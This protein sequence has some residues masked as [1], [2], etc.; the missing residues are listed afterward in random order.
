MK[1]FAF[2]LS[3]S[4]IL[5]GCTSETEQKKKMQKNETILQQKKEEKPKIKELE[6]EEEIVNTIVIHDNPNDAK[7]NLHVPDIDFENLTKW[8]KKNT[9]IY[10]E[11]S[12]TFY[13]KPKFSKDG[14]RMRKVDVFHG[15]SL[16]QTLKYNGVFYAIELLDWNFDGYK[17]F[18]ILESAGATGNYFYQIYLF[19]PISKKFEQKKGFENWGGFLDVKN[20]QLVSHFRSGMDHDS[21]EYYKIKNG[22]PVF[23]HGKVS[24]TYNSDGKGK[25]V[26]KVTRAKMI[27]NKLEK[28]VVF[29]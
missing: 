17:D 9:I 24:S 25:Y 18:S 22:I 13:F 1:I 23:D 2:V 27:H 12:D 19:N 29:E 21:Y 26:T 20:K 14:I 6:K 28:Y 11:T 7:E 10:P 3:V 8:Y 16:I 4:L 15:D 5:I